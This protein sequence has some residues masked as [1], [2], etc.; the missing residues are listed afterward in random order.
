MESV[1]HADRN[2][3]NVFKSTLS[4]GIIV[5]LMCTPSDVIRNY[6]YYNADLHF[7][8][9]TINTFEVAKHL[10][11]TRGLNCFW[12]GLHWTYASVIPG[13][14]IFLISYDHLK[15]HYNPPVASI[16]SRMLAIVVTQPFDC[17]RTH[18]QANLSSNLTLWKIKSTLGSTT[19]YK[20]LFSTILRDI[21][22]SA[23]HWPLCEYFYR[24]ITE[25]T[26]YKDRGLSR[27]ELLVIPFLC[28]SLSATIA[29]VV[30]QP[31]DIVKTKIQANINRMDTRRT[32]I[33]KE[34]KVFIRDYGFRGLL[35]GLLPRL[36]KVVPGSA[37]MAASYRYF[38]S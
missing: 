18:T 24:Y 21:P 22:F 14:T 30:S 10:Y 5:S 2:Y 31:F 16:L 33:S 1:D 8:R 27:M 34:L 28:G 12:T 35:I 13:Q 19:L 23:I 11:Q 26:G 20:G 6:W 29:T 32:S 9:S 36:F 38:I 3:A 37:I 15:Y 17:L 4:G 7:K 25:H